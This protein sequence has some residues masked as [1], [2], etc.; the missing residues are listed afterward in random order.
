[1]SN[2][3]YLIIDSINNLES[4]DQNISEERIKKAERFTFVDDKK[5]CILAEILLRKVLNKL[6]VDTNN[7]NYIYNE[8]GK[9]Y[10][11]DS[12]YY[13]NISHSGEYVAVVVSDVEIGIDIQKIDDINLNIAKRYF[14]QNEYQNII[15]LDNQ[16]SQIDM[17]YDYWTCKEAYVKA[18][19][20]GLACEFNSFDITGENFNYHLYRIDDYDGYKCCLCAKDEINIE[21]VNN[22]E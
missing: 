11:K 12:N 17:F 4:L 19:G 18:I 15:K 3:A 10:L 14:N 13:F 6:N 22:Y 9:P 7:L 8:N 20:K 16:D 2:K 1:M 5:R 21:S